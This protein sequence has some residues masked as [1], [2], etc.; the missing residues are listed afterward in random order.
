[1]TSEERAFVRGFAAATAQ[2][3]RHQAMAVDLLRSIAATE[4]V[5]KA[6]GVDEYDLVELRP[7][8]RELRAKL[9]KRPRTG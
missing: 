8:L 4:R 2:I 5:L 3:V 6:A 1:M 7:A 9:R